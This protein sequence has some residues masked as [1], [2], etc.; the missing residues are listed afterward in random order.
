[1]PEFSCLVCG[2]SDVSERKAAA[3]Y[4]SKPDGVYLYRCNICGAITS[5]DIYTTYD[6]S[7]YN[8]Y[9]NFIE[10][11]PAYIERLAFFQHRAAFFAKQVKS[12]NILDIG[13]GEGHFLDQI[14]QFGFKTFGLEFSSDAAVV[15]IRQGHQV[16]NGRAEYLPF[17]DS[18]FAAVHMNHVLEHVTNP[19]L[20]LTEIRRVLQPTGIGVIEVPNEFGLLAERLKLM[21]RIVG[22]PGQ[23]RLRYNPHVIY[24]NRKSLAYVMR[25]AGLDVLNCRTKFSGKITPSVAT[26]PAMVARLYDRAMGSGDLIEFIVRPQ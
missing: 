19:I 5:S 15:A 17:P 8:Q 20:S 26:L 24:F 16:V 22:K 6:T 18:F 10:G 11:T 13:C 2:S 4:L 7:Y 14:A 9:D 12:G 23:P 25:C 21:L 3:Y 1:M